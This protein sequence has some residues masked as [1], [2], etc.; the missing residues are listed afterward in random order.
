MEIEH[1]SSSMDDIYLRR[2]LGGEY[3][4]ISNL[5]AIVANEEGYMLELMGSKR[6]MS[7]KHFKPS[8]S[9]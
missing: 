8:Y 3:E 9:E 6:N 4:D 7:M 1:E 2:N 5:V